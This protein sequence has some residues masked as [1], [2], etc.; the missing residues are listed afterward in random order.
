VLIVVARVFAFF[1]TL[2]SDNA[3]TVVASAPEGLP[4]LVPNLDPYQADELKRLR[5]RAQHLLSQ[6][7]W[8]DQKAGVARIPIERAMDII[9]NQTPLPKSQQDSPETTHEE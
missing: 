8:I 9:A 6:Y 7:Q 4:Q 1:T 3:S 2:R 5:A